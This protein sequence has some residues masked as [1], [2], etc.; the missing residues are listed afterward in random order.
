MPGWFADVYA[1]VVEPM[2]GLGYRW[3]YANGNHDP[4]ADLSKEEIVQV[5]MQLGIWGGGLS[6][7]QQGEMKV[8]RSR[9]G[10]GELR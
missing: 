5:D 7:T 4:Q 10:D 8:E 9:R 2:M 1:G 3:A 6:R